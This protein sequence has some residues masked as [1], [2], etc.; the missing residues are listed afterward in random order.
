[1]G[2][3]TLGKSRTGRGILGEVWNSSLD[4]LGGP[5]PVGDLR[6]IRDGSGDPRGDVGQDGAS[7]GR[8]W[9]GRGPSGRFGTG[10]GSLGEVQTG[11]WTFGEVWNGSFNPQGG[12]GRVGGL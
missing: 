12:S 3:R 9:T 1:M 11:R 6:E 8:S 4:P 2:R 10:W 7:S 5:G